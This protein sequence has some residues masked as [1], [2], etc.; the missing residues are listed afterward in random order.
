MGKKKALPTA[1]IRKGRQA[2]STNLSNTYGIL[3][4]K[5]KR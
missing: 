4:G 3:V 1:T 5:K 2:V